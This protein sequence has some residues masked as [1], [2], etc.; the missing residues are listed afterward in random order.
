MNSNIKLGDRLRHD[1]KPSEMIECGYLPRYLADLWAR[2]HNKPNPL[3]WTMKYRLYLWGAGVVGFILLLL[4]AHYD[5]SPNTSYTSALILFLF[6]AGTAS[7]LILP[8]PKNSGFNSLIENLINYGF[9][10][11]T[12]LPNTPDKLREAVTF[13]MCD[14]IDEKEKLIAQ[15]KDFNG[16]YMKRFYIAANNLDVAFPG[17]YGIYYKIAAER[18]CRDEMQLF[19]YAGVKIPYSFKPSVVTIS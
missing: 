1:I 15:G 18:R 19:D 10:E 8:N 14:F 4:T 9:R 2:K 6:M 3:H 16:D 17:G 5:P 13:R 7:H 12:S 11:S